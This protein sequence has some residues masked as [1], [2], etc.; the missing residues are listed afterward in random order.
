VPWE[1]SQGVVG[2]DGGESG[3]EILTI[4]SNPASARETQEDVGVG[5]Q[6]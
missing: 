6:V 2:Q 1:G 3:P 4:E 5:T